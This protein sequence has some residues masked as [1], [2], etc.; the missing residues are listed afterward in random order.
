MTSNEWK[1]EHGDVRWYLGEKEIVLKGIPILSN[2]AKGVS[3]V[4]GHDIVKAKQI[5][6]AEEANLRPLQMPIVALLYADIP[7]LHSDKVNV[8][9]KKA[10]LDV[11]EGELKQSRRIHKML[12]DLWQRSMQI[13]YGDVYPHDTFRAEVFGPVAQN[14]RVELIDLEK[15]ELITSVWE[16]GHDAPTIIKLTDKGHELADILWSNMPECMKQ[17]VR[18]TKDFFVLRSIDEIVAYFH[19]KYPEYRKMK[20]PTGE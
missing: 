5:H 12:F 3:L 9:I 1:S 7:L 8:V 17:E 16:K 13:G 20:V 2:K 11:K 14:L 15:R 6:I 19:E 18:N 10:D 4:S